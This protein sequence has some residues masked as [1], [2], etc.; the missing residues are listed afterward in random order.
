MTTCNF[1]YTYPSESET[2]DLSSLRGCYYDHIRECEL[3]DYFDFESIKQDRVEIKFLK[4]HNFDYRRIWR[5]A[6]VWFDDKPVMVIQ[7][8]GREGD[9]HRARFITDAPRFNDMC[10][11][12]K[13]LC[14]IKC[15]VQRDVVD[16]TVDI[17]NLTC[18]YGNELSGYFERY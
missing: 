15:E 6:T 8:A 7:N 16:A 12:I 1:L 2:T 5:L 10:D 14:T 11:Y 3:S 9:D 17:E 18:F 13:A 4:N